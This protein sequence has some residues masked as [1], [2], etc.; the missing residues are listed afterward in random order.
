MNASS[1]SSIS[2]RSVQLCLQPPGNLPLQSARGDGWQG[3]ALYK[4]LDSGAYSR[5]EFKC[6]ICFTNSVR[7][8]P[9]SQ[10]ASSFDQAPSYTCCLHACLDMSTHTFGLRCDA[11]AHKLLLFVAL[12]RHPTILNKIANKLPDPPDRSH[13]NNNWNG[14]C[15]ANRTTSRERKRFWN[16]INS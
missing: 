4:S 11:C 2:P 3:L 1:V 16:Q 14:I 6:F 15:V 13:P 7:P 5:T 10:H 9:A 8:D 12:L